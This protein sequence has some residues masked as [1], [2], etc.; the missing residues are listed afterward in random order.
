[1]EIHLPDFVIAELYTDNLVVI[2]TSDEPALPHETPP[3]DKKINAI[4]ANPQLHWL[5]DNKQNISIVVNDADNTFIGEKELELL[6][7]ILTACKF[8][9]SDVAIINIAK[10]PTDFEQLIE[11]A[12]SRWLLL[13]GVDAQKISL[14]QPL[15]LFE[16]KVIKN[17]SCLYSPSLET[18]TQPA[19]ET[20]ALKNKLWRALKKMN[21]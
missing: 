7:N 18:L 17:V 6:T 3:K 20:T 13:F 1:M 21:V 15:N 10:T 2:P 14:P 12:K 4:A 19:P 5:G 16:D 11:T 9:I 8:N